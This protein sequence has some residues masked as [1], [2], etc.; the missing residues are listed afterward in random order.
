MGGLPCKELD[1]SRPHL[2]GGVQASAGEREV[3]S[4]GLEN[5]RASRCQLAE[6]ILLDDDVLDGNFDIVELDLHEVLA[7]HRVVA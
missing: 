6:T 1:G 4:A 2:G 5:R 3:K 7:A